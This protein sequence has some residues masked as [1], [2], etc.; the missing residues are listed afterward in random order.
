MFEDL[1]VEL[2]TGSQR[3]SGRLATTS[4]SLHQT[5]LTR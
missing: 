4:N 5:G 2:L 3:D 1:E